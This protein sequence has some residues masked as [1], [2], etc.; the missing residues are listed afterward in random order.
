MLFASILM[1]ITMVTFLG[2]K[3]ARKI[4]IFTISGQV[5][6]WEHQFGWAHIRPH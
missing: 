2:L 5:S 3:L 4:P 6:K 1:E